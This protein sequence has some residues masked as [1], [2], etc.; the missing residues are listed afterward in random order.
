TRVGAHAAVNTSVDLTRTVVGEG[1][2]KFVNAVLRKVDRRGGDL[3]APDRDA[4]PLGYLAINYA[5]PKWIVSA[6]KDALHGDIDHTEAAL[7]ASDTRPSVHLVARPGRMTPVELVAACADAGYAAAPGPWSP[8]S[9]R[10][11]GG[12]VTTLQPIRDGR[13]GV[14]DEGSQLAA[15]VAVRAARGGSDLLDL[16]A[17]PGGKAALLAGSLRHTAGGRLVAVE[18]HAHR[19]ALVRRSLAAATAGAST[20]TV[21]LQADGTVPA[22]PLATFDSVLVDAPCTGL[23]ALRRRP[24]ARWRRQPSDV[25]ALAAVQRRLLAAAID[26]AKPGGRITYVVC[27]PHLAEGRVIVADALK[28][29]GDV[30]AIDVR[31]FLDGV[32]DLGD[33][34]HAQLWPHLHG[35]DAMFVAVLERVSP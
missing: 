13:A 24:E 35:T 1:A 9:V 25:P 12:D 14:Q 27:S 20:R 33:G 2:S 34:P 26:A 6:F 11:D 32:P 18:P 8:Y 28:R 19:A 30:V 31:E 22:W 17:G 4:D 29:R 5:H 7:A 15:L 16:C 10:L 3:G 23:G 21:A